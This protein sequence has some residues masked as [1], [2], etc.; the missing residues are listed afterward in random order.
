[1]STRTEAR[2]AVRP[3]RRRRTGL[4]AAIVTA[5]MASMV[6]ASSSH[7]EPASEVPQTGEELIETLRGLLPETLEITESSGSGLDEGPDAYA[8]LLAADGSGGTSLDL[9]FFRWATE[10]DFTGGAAHGPAPP[11]QRFRA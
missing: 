10:G 1:M 9:S 11:V 4:S 7:A 5:A 6:A 3:L 8:S 2:T